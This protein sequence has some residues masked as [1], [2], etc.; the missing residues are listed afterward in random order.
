M[1]D[2]NYK[3]DH[4]YDPNKIAINEAEEPDGEN[5]LIN[6][7]LTQSGASN[8]DSTSLTIM[9]KKS[10]TQLEH[11]VMKKSVTFREVR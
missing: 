11:E 5:L 8:R 1:F 6:K 9:S 4:H 10:N 3:I 2:R 7:D